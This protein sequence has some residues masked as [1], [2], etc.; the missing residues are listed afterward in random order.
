M[1]LDAAKD[2]LRRH[3][4]D[5]ILGLLNRETSSLE[6]GFEN[7]RVRRMLI[8]NVFFEFPTRPSIVEWLERGRVTTRCAP[9]LD[10]CLRVVWLEVVDDVPQPKNN[11][12]PEAEAQFG[13]S[14]TLIVTGRTRT[15][16][17]FAGVRKTERDL[18][19]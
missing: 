1:C 15:F 7:P 12:H 5:C 3:R 16:P 4:V 17:G 19:D 9:R 2:V 10:T 13:E 18:A 14:M 11:R 8:T 6:H